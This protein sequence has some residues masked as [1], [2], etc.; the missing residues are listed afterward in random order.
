LT[1]LARWCECHGTTTPAMRSTGRAITLV[2]Q[3]L[4]HADLKTTS[5]YAHVRPN[6]SPTRYF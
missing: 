6:D 3:T 5:V 4:G 2:S 1:Q